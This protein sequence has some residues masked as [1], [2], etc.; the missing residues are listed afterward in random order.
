MRGEL[1]Q[2]Q[3]PGTHRALRH[4]EVNTDVLLDT[5]LSRNKLA[6]AR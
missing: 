5:V 3:A 1:A 4:D 6:R 2:A